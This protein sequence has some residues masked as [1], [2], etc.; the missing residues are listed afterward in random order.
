M[1]IAMQRRM[2][3]LQLSWRTRGIQQPLRMRIGINTGYCNVG[4]FGSTDRMDYTIIG[5]EVNL[6]ARLEEHADPDGI[7]LSY[8]TYALVRGSVTAEEWPAIEAKGIRREIRPYAL[9]DFLDQ[10]AAHQII[11]SE[12]EGMYVR[13]DVRDLDDTRRQA[14]LAELAD[15]TERLKAPPRR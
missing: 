11:N 7:L 15:I 9:T 8:E 2:R 4:N 10:P 13:I 14:M 12:I 1:A 6:A 5:G 3:E